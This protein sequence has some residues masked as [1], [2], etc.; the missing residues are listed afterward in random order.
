MKDRVKEIIIGLL[1]TIVV[2]LVFV[3]VFYKEIANTSIV[4]KAVAY[5]PDADVQ[6]EREDDTIED[7]KVEIVYSIDASD[8]NLYKQSKSYVQGKVDPFSAIGQSSES[9]NDQGSNNSTSTGN[10]G[11]QNNNNS[12]TTNS[13]ASSN[14]SEN[15]NTSNNDAGTTTNK[16]SDFGN[17]TVTYY[18]TST[19]K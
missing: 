2:I 4:P 16:S 17:Y 5:E 13:N 14:A 3:I 7:E 9:T 12:N 1:I 8:L 19:G 11:T 15:Q 10:S 18:N 6:A